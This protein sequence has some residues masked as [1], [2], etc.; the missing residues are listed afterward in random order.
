VKKMS[1]AMIIGFM[2]DAM[3]TMLMI[4]APL[5]IVAVA[6]GLIISVLQATTQIQEQ[7]LVFVPKIVVTFGTLLFMLPFI[8]H[9]MNDFTLGM[10]QNIAN[11][12][13]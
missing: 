3:L 6:V 5:L 11:I 13:R 8:M 12:L 4:S 2:R 7:T 10:F 9:K 1:E